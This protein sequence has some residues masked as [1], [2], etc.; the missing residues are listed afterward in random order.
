[1]VKQLSGLDL[2]EQLARLARQS[3]TPTTAE[4]ARVTTAGAIPPAW[5]IQ[6]VSHES[7]NQYKVCQVRLQTPGT[8]PVPTST[9]DI[10]ATNIAESFTTNGSLAVGTYAV[11]WRI[12]DVYVFYAHP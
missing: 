7:Y 8:T 4:H 6:V 11:M 1:M 10:L 5:A 9:T 3:Q 2:D 12:G